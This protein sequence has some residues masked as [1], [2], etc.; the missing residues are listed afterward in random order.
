MRKRI[1]GINS[2][3][4]VVL[5]SVLAILL[6]SCDDGRIYDKFHDFDANVWHMDSTQTFS[7][8]I[9]DNEEEYSFFYLIRNTADYS[10]YNLYLKFTIEDSL[11]QVVHSELQELI[12][13]DPKTGKPY[14]SG[15]GDIFSHEFPAI[16]HI[17]LPYA[18]TYTFAVRQYMRT[19]NLN[20][21]QSVGLKIEKD[22]TE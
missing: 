18:G 1:I 15:L 20:G 5:S 16:E 22:L 10:Y 2:I 19:E 3:G 12:L 8:D 11:H 4:L 13:F 7:F 6:F 21:I 14:G 9:K 17:S